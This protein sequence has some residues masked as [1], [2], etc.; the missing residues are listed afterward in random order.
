[1]K[2][3]QK[4]GLAPLSSRPEAGRLGAMPTKANAAEWW[5][6]WNE[7]HREQIKAYN[8]EVEENGLWSDGYRL[9]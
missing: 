6:Q 9:F 7:E 4:S 3:A 1:M 2:N 5:E 8:A